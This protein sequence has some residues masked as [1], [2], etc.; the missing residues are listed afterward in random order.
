MNYQIYMQS[1]QWR[2]KALFIK[3]LA[4]IWRCSFLPLI[5]GDAH[6]VKYD[7]LT[8]E[9]YLR[10]IVIVGPIVHILI[11]HGFLSGCRRPGQQENYPNTLQS[12]VHF[13]YRLP[14]VGGLF[15]AGTANILIQVM[16]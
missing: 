15:L 7:N 5:F 3:I 2:A 12:M 11:I 8:N 13:F 16:K 6:H 10:D 14:L 1:K 9:L 4:C